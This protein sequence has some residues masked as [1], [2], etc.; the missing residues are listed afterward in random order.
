MKRFVFFGV[1]LFLLI[2]ASDLDVNP[3]EAVR[4]IVGEAADQGFGGMVDVGEVIRNRGSVRGCYGLNARHSR[5]EAWTTWGEATAA[6][7]VSTFTNRTKGATK[8]ENIYQFGFPESWDRSRA[9]CVYQER[10]HW[11]FID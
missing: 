10:D 1:G 2:C 9:V 5:R 4:V 3:V 7:M 6:W 8:F 11:F